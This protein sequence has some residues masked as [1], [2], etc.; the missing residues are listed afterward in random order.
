MFII[1]NEK[2]AGAKELKKVHKILISSHL[3]EVEETKRISH[4]TQLT[5][6]VNIFKQFINGDISK[7]KYLKKYISNIVDNDELHSSL[8]ML[9]LAHQQEDKNGRPIALVCS[10][11]EMGFLYLKALG[12]YIEK[13]FEIPVITYKECKKNKFKMIKYKLNKKY[14]SKM[15]SNYKHLLFDDYQEYSKTVSEFDDNVKKKDK[16]KSKNKEK[17]VKKNRKEVMKEIQNEA[18]F[19]FVKAA[20]KRHI[21]TIK[22]KK[23]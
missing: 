15:I 10:S 4:L 22:R 2:E 1:C 12:K 7:K 23:K 13:T 16:K 6:S 19:D 21:I 18:D 20:N 17:D 3:D 8:I 11:D 14:L 9:I 5:P